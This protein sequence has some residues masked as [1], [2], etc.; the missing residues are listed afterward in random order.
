MR[1]AI[2][3]MC[4]LRFTIYTSKRYTYEYI[5]LYDWL[6]KITYNI[7]FTLYTHIM[8]TLLHI[9][10]SYY[11]IGCFYVQYTIYNLSHI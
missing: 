8:Y 7:Q 5:I 3:I 2:E 11:I 6:F 4:N 10:L 1:E 9:R